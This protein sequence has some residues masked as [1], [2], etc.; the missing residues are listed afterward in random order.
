MTLTEAR[1]VLEKNIG[2]FDGEIADAIAMAITILPKKPDRPSAED[3]LDF[4]RK[5]LSY[6]PFNGQKIAKHAAWRQCI[7]YKLYLEGFTNA[8]ISV[9]TGLNHATVTHAIQSVV[10]G[11]KYG[12]K[13]I[14]KIWAE[15]LDKT[16]L[17]S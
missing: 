9:A 13:L 17:K 4:I 3:R 11:L 2:S 12:D 6:N 8:E 5:V 10:D 7:I 1:I 14:H 16:T 15:L